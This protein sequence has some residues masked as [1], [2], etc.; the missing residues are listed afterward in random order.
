MTN[1]DI[2]I[3]TFC[4]L[5]CGIFPENLLQAE[6]KNY[7]KNE[8]LFSES[9]NTGKIGI[10][11]SG[12]AKVKRICRDGGSFDMSILESGELFG[13]AML[14]NENSRFDSVVTAKTACRVAFVGREQLLEIFEKYPS[15]SGNYIRILS[16]KIEILSKKLAILSCPEPRD[17]LTAF[18][19]DC[20]TDENG[21]VKT[22]FSLSQLAN[23]LNTGRSTLYRMLNDEN[24]SYKLTKD[25]KIKKVSK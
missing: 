17:R 8:I 7:E 6:I 3:I 1:K 24:S 15:V 11:L 14:F 10:I 20:G 22:D 23:H 18:F 9:T 5:F 12:R 13:M 2:Q 19:E 25:G 4:P 16:S 21:T